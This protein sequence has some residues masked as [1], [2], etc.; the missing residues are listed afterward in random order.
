MRDSPENSRSNSFDFAAMTIDSALRVFGSL[1]LS[2]AHLHS[3][4]WP[5]CAATRGLWI[6]HQLVAGIDS[7]AAIHG[8]HPDISIEDLPSQDEQYTNCTQLTQSRGKNCSSC[9]VAKVV[10][11]KHTSGLMKPDAATVANLARS[12]KKAE[13]STLLAGTA[14]GSCL[15]LSFPVYICDVSYYVFICVCVCV[16]LQRINTSD[17]DTENSRL[18]R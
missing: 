4:C 9:L 15:P 3:L 11:N 13:E 14:E 6:G 5:H 1:W 12:C 17:S 16:Y 7:L 2:L 8:H 18:N 10:D